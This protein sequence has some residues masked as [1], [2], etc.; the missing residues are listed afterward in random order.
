MDTADFLRHLQ[1]LLWYEDQLVHLEQV[2]SRTP[3]FADLDPPLDP[4]LS[5]R[6]DSIG[7]SGLYSHQVTAIQ[8]LRDGKNV[9]VA[10][11]SRQRQEHVLQ[12]AR[13]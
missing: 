7:V 13:P 12:P 5:A 9:I 1:S 6:L 2:P 10:T 4:R 11:P 3:R 8:A